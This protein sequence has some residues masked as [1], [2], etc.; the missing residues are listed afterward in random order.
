MK[1][2]FDFDPEEETG[3][4]IPRAKRDEATKRVADFVRE[5][6]L[7]AVGEGRSPVAGEGRFQALS[8]E[9]KKR[10]SEISS[11]TIPNLELYGDMLDSLEVVEVRGGKLRLKVG[12]DQNDKADGHC[13]FSGKS[14]IPRR[15]FV[16]NAKDGQT[17]SRDII[18]GIKDIL[19]EYEEEA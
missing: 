18:S 11:S 16:P 7:S 10:K 15:R 5:S 14:K 13:N 1:I 9:Y 6:V 12:E 4:T 19:S 2:Q 17:F 3:I 8:K